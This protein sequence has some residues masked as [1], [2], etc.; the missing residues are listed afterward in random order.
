MAKIKDLS[1]SESESFYWLFIL[2]DAAGNPL[3]LNGAL[4]EWAVASAEDNGPTLLATSANGLIVITSAIDG[5]GYVLVPSA[6]HSTIVDGEYTH[7]LRAT[8][9]T[10]VVTTQISGRMSVPP[11]TRGWSRRSRN[12]KR[13]QCGSPAHAGMVPATAARWRFRFRFPRPRGDGPRKDE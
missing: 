13:R 12:R 5:E 7:E 8:L 1:F 2:H 11:P 10:N 6:S 9:A 3:D 4:V